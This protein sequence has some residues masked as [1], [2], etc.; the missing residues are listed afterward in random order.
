MSIVPEFNVFVRGTALEY[1]I[2]DA[3]PYIDAIE[4]IEIEEGDPTYAD[5]TTALFPD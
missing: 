3:D 2:P 4:T 1:F 5:V